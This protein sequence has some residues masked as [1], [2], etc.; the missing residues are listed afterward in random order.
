MANQPGDIQDAAVT[1]QL[2]TEILEA[3]GKNLDAIQRGAGDTADVISNLQRAIESLVS[4]GGGSGQSGD[5]TSAPAPSPQSSALPPRYQLSGAAPSQPTAAPSSPLPPASR[6]RETAAPRDPVQRNFAE[7]LG[8]GLKDLSSYLTRNIDQSRPRVAVDDYQIGQMSRR[9]LDYN[10]QS[11]QSYRQRI[12]DLGQRTGMSLDE[13]KQLAFM[14]NRFGLGTS[15]GV[16][17]TST[18]RI[19][20]F[21][22]GEQAKAAAEAAFGLGLNRKTYFSTLQTLG[23]AGAV[24]AAGAAGGQQQDYRQF[25]TTIAETLA[26]GRLFDRMDDVMASIGELASNISA[27]GGIVDPQMLASAI[28]SANLTALDSGSARLQERA[29]KIIQDIGTFSASQM[30]DPMSLAMNLK[31]GLLGKNGVN[32]SDVLGSMDIMAGGDVEAQSRSYVE[33]FKTFGGNLGALAGNKSAKDLDSRSMGAIFAMSQ[34]QGQSPQQILDMLRIANGVGSNRAGSRQSE[35]Q[36]DATYKALT[37]KPGNE[38][39]AQL[40][41]RAKLASGAELTSILEEQSGKLA[42]VHPVATFLPGTDENKYYNTLQS[43]LAMAKS[44]NVEGARNA[45]L[46]TLSTAPAS[47]RVTGENQLESFA[48]QTAELGRA[49]DTLAGQVNQASAALGIN[50]G[51]AI[52]YRALIGQSAADYADPSQATT[53]GT[54]FNWYR[55]TVGSTAMYLPG[56]FQSDKSD[57]SGGFFDSIGKYLLASRAAQAIAGSR[58]AGIGMRFLRGGLA[59]GAGEVAGEILDE[60]AP[61]AR[62]NTGAGTKDEINVGAGSAARIAGWTAAGALA[63]SGLPVLGNIALGAAGFAYGTYQELSSGRM[64]LGS[65]TNSFFPKSPSGGGGTVTPTGGGSPITIPA[66]ESLTSNIPIQTRL[67]AEIAM[68]TT[69]SNQALRLLVDASGKGGEFA[70]GLTELA[71]TARSVLPPVSK[72]NDPIRVPGGRVATVEGARQTAGETGTVTVVSPPSAAAVAQSRA[73]A[74]QA[75]IPRGAIPRVV[76]AVGAAVA[77]IPDAVADIYNADD[78]LK[79][80]MPA[81]RKVITAGTSR[82]AETAPLPAGISDRIAP[83]IPDLKRMSERTGIEMSALAAQIFIESSWDPNARNAESGGSGFGQITP[84]ALKDLKQIGQAGA[85]MTLDDLRG[86]DE[87]T[88]H[89][90]LL[91][92]ERYL[93]RVRQLHGN[94]TNN[95]TVLDFYGTGAGYSGK[96]RELQPKYKWLDSASVAGPAPAGGGLERP[97]ALVNDAGN[98]FVTFGSGKDQSH[99]TSGFMQ[100]YEG[101]TRPNIGVD[102]AAHMGQGVAVPERGVLVSVQHNTAESGSGFGKEFIS[103]TKEVAEGLPEPGGRQWTKGSAEWG[104]SVGFLGE[105]GTFHRLSHLQDNVAAGLQVGQTLEAGTVVG[106]VGMSG[107]TTGPHL[108]WQTEA[109]DASGKWRL[110]SSPAWRHGLMEFAS[111]SNVTGIP[112]ASVTGAGGSDIATGGGTMNP[113]GTSPQQIQLVIKL[114]QDDNGKINGTLLSAPVALLAFN[115]HDPLA[116]NF[117]SQFRLNPVVASSVP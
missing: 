88:G 67:L 103:G 105:S 81:A 25:A 116:Q 60:A 43:Q 39:S 32:L 45:F 101:T 73:A 117:Q 114:E 50:R 58:I 26:T 4:R 7:I 82:H 10:T 55:G 33:R 46:Q 15:G 34:L 5:Q 17:T 87:A 57:S 70:A 95:D 9:A 109:Q 83:Y 52:T 1:N 94:T 51:E 27:R 41:S 63:G 59:A 106:Q 96:V 56:K 78:P 53:M 11:L 28:A 112:N 90:N 42:R 108:D 76:D 54:G 62:Y 86:P 113:S 31:A 71:T 92:M 13:S 14:S 6:D 47:L 99:P 38:Q 93:Q 8:R 72:P 20:S 100:V 48:V 16:G 91:M 102:W 36:N 68:Q 111:G 98:Q 97:I 69:V 110:I 66:V 74:A 24:G 61:G 2:L 75:N 115:K 77:A 64:S 40:Y 21:D 29:P 18:G 30:N 85:D 79:A 37:S 12:F 65:L 49:F 84:I 104:N 89:L 107:R 22:Q 3:M 80:I 23:Q 35:L 19:G 44:G